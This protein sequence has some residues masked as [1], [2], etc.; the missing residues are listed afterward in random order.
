MKMNSF[1]GLFALFAILFSSAAAAQDYVITIQGDTIKGDV[2]ALTYGADKKVQVT[3]PG[4][5]RVIFPIFKIKSFN[6]NGEMFQPVKGPKG[7]SF[8]KPVKTGYLSLFAFQEENQNTYGAMYLL[9]KD[10]SGMEVPNLAFKKGMSKFLADCSTVVD[11]IENEDLKKKDL[12]RIVDEYNACI[13]N[14]PSGARPLLAEQKVITTQPTKDTSAWDKL[15]ATVNAQADFPEKENALEMIKEIKSKLVASQKIPNFLVDGLKNAL[16][17]EVFKT[18]LENA[19][20]E[21]N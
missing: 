20:A 17:Q 10:G 2:K 19:L 7:Y 14:R 12:H 6:I 15:E 8:M 21:I 3:E 11:L 18:D 5:K 1:N 13:E 4:K 9:K 16:N